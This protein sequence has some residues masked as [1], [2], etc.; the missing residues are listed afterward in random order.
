MLVIINPLIII[1]G[2]VIIFIQKDN[3]KA[4][5]NSRFLKIVHQISIK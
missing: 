2:I 1:W 5:K 3:K 4:K